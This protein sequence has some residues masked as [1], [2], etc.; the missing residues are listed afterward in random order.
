MTTATVIAVSVC[1]VVLVAATVHNARRVTPGDA[2]LLDRLV[3]PTVVVAG[4]L[5]AWH[6]VE[7]A[8]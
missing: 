2:T 6:L 4:A 1:L 7:V 5:L 8:A 3:L